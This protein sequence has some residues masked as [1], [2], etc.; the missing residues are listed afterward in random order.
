MITVNSL[1]MLVMI[2]QKILKSIINEDA[3][4][5]TEI[6]KRYEKEI[7]KMLQKARLRAL[8]LEL[9]DLEHHKKIKL[10][11]VNDQILHRNIV[12]LDEV[13]ILSKIFDENSINYCFIKGVSSLLHFNELMPKR[14]TSDID[15]LVDINNLKQLHDVL[16][17]QKLNPI[18]DYSYDYSSSK[19]NHSFERIKLKSGLYIDFHFRITSPL[20]FKDCPLSNYVMENSSPSKDFFG[21]R[22]TN[23]TSIYLIA[24]YQI[25]IKK[26]SDIRTG[27]YV[28]LVFLRQNMNFNTIDLDKALKDS[29]LYDYHK[30]LERFLVYLIKDNNNKNPEMDEF[31]K[32]IFTQSKFNFFNIKFALVNTLYFNQLKIEKYG[33]LAKKNNLY[34]SLKFFYDKFIKLLSNYFRKN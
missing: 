32:K 21:V 16:S 8:F 23:K 18:F 25:F 33:Y 31:I 27:S 20:H 12:I 1:I 24:L 7:S 15:V 11:E 9:L 19:I 17:K 14:F 28:D 29:F 5:A 13:K 3:N 34:F 10:K 6:Y 26:E 4:L 30:F 2:E 22:V